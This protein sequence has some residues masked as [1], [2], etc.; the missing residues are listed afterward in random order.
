LQIVADSSVTVIARRPAGATK[1]SRSGRRGACRPG[2]LRSAR[3]DRT[4]RYKS[5]PSGPPS[6]GPA[7]ASRAG[8]R[9][10]K[11]QARPQRWIP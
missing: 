2:S 6:L 7:A 4:R 10:S 8:S 3:D 11:Q 1:Q 5:T 9:M